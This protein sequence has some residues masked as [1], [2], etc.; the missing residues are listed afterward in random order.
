MV[1]IDRWI[2]DLPFSERYSFYTRANAGEV[3]PHPPSPL[4]FSTTWVQGTMLGWHDSMISVGTCDPDE[5]D[6][7]EVIGVFGGYLYINAAV[8]R[9][10]GVRGPNLSAEMIDFTYFGDHPDV[11]PYV[12][13]PWHEHPDATAKIGAWMT[14]VLTGDL[15]VLLHD[16]A[17]ADRARDERPDL[18]RLSDH[19][20]VARARSFL[21]AIRR[22]FERHIIVTAGTSIGSGTINA[23]C[24]AV[25]D[26]TLGLKLIS[27]VGDV[28]SALPSNAMWALSRLDPESDEFRAG[29]DE[30]LYRYGSRGP[31]E[32]DVLSDTWETDRQ[33]A[34]DLIEV[35]RKQDDDGDP[36]SR[37]AERA[38][39]REAVTEQ[40]R[41]ALA[42][43]AEALG[44]F[45]AGL[46]SAHRYL[47]GRERAKTNIIKVINEV[48]LAFR[49]LASRHDYD[50][51]EFHMLL[52]DELEAF[53]TAPDEFRARLAQRLEEYRRIQGIEPPFIITSPPDVSTWPA[54]GVS[55]AGVATTGDVLTGVPGCP[56]TATGTARVIL[57]PTDPL[58]LEPGE[59]L[60]APL[61][62]PAWTPLFVPSAAVVVDVGAQVSHAI[63]VSRE[64]GLPCV[65]SVTGATQSIP[66]GATI[67]VDGDAGTVTVDA[68]P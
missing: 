50:L 36:A 26:P 28:D 4:A 24:E 19:E 39:E 29:F 20:L 62:D 21:P 27:G 45:E 12:P 52:D 59:I 10:F 1:D 48:R 25:G 32:W 33:L 63:I 34:L 7:E 38:A 31:N 49:E 14:E 22:L 37:H 16:Q 35:M 30:F 5:L 60:V 9:L 40:L 18:T 2:T 13:E 43:D 47:A 55:S 64:L 3:L 23:I 68:L 8:S 17:E 53:L 6:P 56:G 66:D 54:K 42:A 46:A 65:V 11:P 58:A 15:E 51:A 67:T 41:T 57:D 61:T 44:Q